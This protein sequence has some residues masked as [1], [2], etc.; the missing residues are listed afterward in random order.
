MPLSNRINYIVTSGSK[1]KASNIQQMM[2]LLGQQT[3]DQKRV[4]LGFSNRTLPHYPRFENGIESRGF[5][6]SNFMNGL[7]PQEYFFHAMAGRE[8]VI[9]TAVKTANSGYLQRKLIKSMED[10]KVAH[11][12]TVRTSNNEIVQFCY[13]YDGFNSISLEKQKTNFTKIS[14]ENFK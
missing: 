14:I 11:D 3:I 4:P 7:N 8:G 13:G 10:L 1:G 9:D 5:I 2:C 6:S 12:Y